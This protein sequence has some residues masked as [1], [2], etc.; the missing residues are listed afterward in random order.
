M[1]LARQ[2]KQVAPSSLTVDTQT[3]WDQIHA[4]AG[5]LEPTD[6]ETWRAALSSE[7]VL[8][9]ET[10]RRLLDKPG[11]SKWFAWS[12]ESERGTRL[13]ALFCALIESAKVAGLEPAA[14]VAEA[15]GRAS[16]N[17]GTVTLPRDLLPG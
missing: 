12:A 11:S 1:P 5:H 16:G 17:P 8:A 14:C 7:V 13:A 9:D 2:V 10:Q 6:E 15:T 4:L 3:L